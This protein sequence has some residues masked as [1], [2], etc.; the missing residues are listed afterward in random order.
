V[1][2]F[3]LAAAA[4]LAIPA[5]AQ[6]IAF[7]GGTVAIG[8]GS[9]PAPGTVV[10]RDGRVVAAGPNV[11]VP[12]GARQ[13]DATG[14]WVAAGMVA[15][16]T[17]EGIVDG[18]GISETY[19]ARARTSPFN[20]A[21]DVLVAVNPDS[22]VI[23]VDRAGGVTRAL[24]APE[25]GN[26]IFAGQGAVIDLGADAAAVT[27][28]KAFQFVELGENS[29]GL[30]GGSRPAAYALLHDAL[31]QAQDYR[32]NP[33]GFDGRTRD[34]LLK[35]SDAAALL[36]VLDG[37]IPLVV[38]VERRSDILQVLD[39]RRQYPQVKLVLLGATEG[40]MVAR[41]IAAARVPVLAAA[42]ADL[43]AAFESVGATESNA[44]RLEAAG[45]TV[46]LATVDISAQGGQ[47]ILKQFAGNLVAIA[48]VPGHT[49]LDW[50]HA[51]A[52]ITSGPAAALG[53]DGEI[54]S[55]RPGRRA[56]VVVWDG[57]PLE[58]A[59]APVGVWID[60]VEQPL[61]NR[62]TKLRDRYLTPQEGALPKA[63]E[64]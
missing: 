28:A 1:K 62:Q 27:R 33:A 55:L 52:A 14:K 39:L 49:G 41:E 36:P 31:A 59:S 15:G 4:L 24:V 34:A 12:A 63:Y 47:R 18:E 40:W 57:D 3:L 58:L 29:A 64:R 53:M 46:G 5:A 10:I 25:P 54:G 19:D 61:A 42:L 20:A 22:P 9:A 60:G 35:R 8:D 11:A 23:A 45:V 17:S 13:V 51:F 30:A 56:D 32:R 44:G 2:A 6:T 21:V 50:G 7:T 26:S 38:H 43:P 48:K 37:R 16:W